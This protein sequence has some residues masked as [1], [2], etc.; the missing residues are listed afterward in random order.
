VVSLLE[1]NKLVLVWMVVIGFRSKA[2]A[3]ALALFNSIDG[4]W[5]DFPASRAI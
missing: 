1:G 4:R 3:T 2:V 5:L